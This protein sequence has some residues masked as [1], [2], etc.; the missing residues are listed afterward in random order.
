MVFMADFRADPCV[1]LG[2]NGSFS[3][4]GIFGFDLWAGVHSEFEVSPEDEGGDEGKI[5]RV[6]SLPKLCS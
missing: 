1:H 2:Q 5:K 4:R 3:Q 6:A